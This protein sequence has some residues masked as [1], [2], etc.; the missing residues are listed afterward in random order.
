VTPQSQ[1]SIIRSIVRIAPTCSA[2]RFDFVTNDECAAVTGVAIVIDVLRAF[3]FCA[4]AL[5]AGIARLIVMDDLDETLAVSRRIP[6]AIA[7]KDG[8]PADGFELFNSPGQL[9]ER[10]LDR[11]RGLGGRTL[12]HRTGAGTVG[13]VAARHAEHVFCASFVVAE[14][15]ADRVRALD[16]SHVTFVISGNDG[17]ADDDLACAEYLA[18][19]I[20]GRSVDPTPYLDRVSVVGQGLRDDLARGYRGIHVDDVDLCMDIDRFDFAMRAVDGDDGLLEVVRA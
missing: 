12:V 2:V 6:G 8:A 11:D 13:A 14:A 3:S 1:A 19:R 15:T 17:R 4:F 5:D 16:P 18:H 7:G 10:E 9:L 20:E